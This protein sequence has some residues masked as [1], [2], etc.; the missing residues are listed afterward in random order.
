MLVKLLDQS[1]SVTVSNFKIL[2]GCGH[3]VMDLLVTPAFR[4]L[5]KDVIIGVLAL[6]NA[7]LSDPTI[8]LELLSKDLAFNSLEFELL[9]LLVADH[10]Q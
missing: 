2:L 1:V 7:F 9:L 6:K 8:D 10:F 5:R 4:Q 3:V